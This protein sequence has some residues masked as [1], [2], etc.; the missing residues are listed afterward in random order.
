MSLE[1]IL[2][3]E[4]EADALEAYRWY[5]EQLP[6]LGED[7]L[8]E[9]DR[10]LESIRAN[11]EAHRKLH[12]EFR[13]VLTRR[14]RMAS[15]MRFEATESWCSPFFIR[16]GSSALEEACRQC[17][18]T[19]RSSRTVARRG[20]TVL[21]MDCVLAGAER[22]GARPLNSIVRHDEMESLAC[23]N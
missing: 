4:A 17:P 16:R 20:R 5:S 11:P 6:G 21:A 14:F 7:F 12:R 10:A 1:L 22:H 13:R 23:L 3:P 8:A 2:R 18:L 19:T 15:S 9:I